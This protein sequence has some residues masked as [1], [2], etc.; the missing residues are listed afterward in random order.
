M[1]KF[2]E[3]PELIA[4]RAAWKAEGKKVVFTNGCYDILHP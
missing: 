2:Y 3:R 1:A 4:E